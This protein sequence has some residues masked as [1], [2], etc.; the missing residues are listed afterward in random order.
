MIQLLQDQMKSEG[1]SFLVEHLPRIGTTS[2]DIC[3]A[4]QP[5]IVSR[6]PGRLCVE[7]TEE[8]NATILLPGEEL[9]G[10]QAKFTTVSP[11]CYRLRLKSREE[12]VNAF[13]CNNKARNVF[14]SLPE[15]K[16]SKKEL[17]E[18]KGFRILCLTCRTDIINEQNCFKINEM[19]SEFWMELMDYWHCHKPH[20]VSKENEYSVR[21]NSLKPLTGEIL[22]GSAF[23]LAQQDT[24]AGRVKTEN[25]FLQCAKCSASLG[26]ETQDHL[27]KIYKWQVLLRKSNKEEDIFPPEQDVVFTLLN[28]IKGYSTR[29]VLLESET[30]KLFVWLFAIGIDVT[31]PDN[32]VLTN[33]IKVLYCD[34]I[35]EKETR[36]S[37]IEQVKVKPV[38][39]RHFVQM[40]EQI[41][42]SLPSS[43]KQFDSWRVSYIK[44]TA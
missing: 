39:M 14:M 4:G 41:H 26:E 22:L 12:V 1:L 2:I 13:N 10:E 25:G 31:L 43:V 21:Y 36:G 34:E 35:S 44:I 24:F 16:W 32:R 27:F 38:P 29:Y 18:S 17:I 20:D 19:P 15:G 42:E 7:D 11:G 37:N 23:F 6:G 8:N 30:S 5:V 33:C 9:V 40:L 3:A 28:L